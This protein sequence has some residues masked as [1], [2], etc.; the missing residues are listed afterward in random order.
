MARAGSAAWRSARTGTDSPADSQTLR[1]WS[2]QRAVNCSHSTGIQGGCPGWVQ[3]GRNRLAAVNG[4]TVRPVWDSQPNLDLLTLR[5][6][7]WMT[8]WHSA[9]TSPMA[10][11]DSDNK[12]RIWDTATGFQ[13]LALETRGRRP[14]AWRWVGWTSPRCH[15]HGRVAGEGA[16]TG[17][18][19]RGAPRALGY[20]R[21]SV[22]FSPDGRYLAAQ[23]PNGREVEFPTA[24]TALPATPSPP[25]LIRLWDAST[26]RKVR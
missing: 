23:D 24:A 3:P 11:I 17:R 20:G 19:F 26:G 13:Y 7:R 15:E 5:A 8:L 22:T 21:L 10:S 1:V 9:P 25:Y 18:Y 6:R 14:T 16:A 4:G 2:C 12:V